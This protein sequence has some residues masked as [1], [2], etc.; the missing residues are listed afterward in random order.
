MTYAKTG[1]PVYSCEAHR[2]RY[3][4]ASERLACY[5]NVHLSH[6]FTNLESDISPAYRESLGSEHAPDESGW[7]TNT[8]RESDDGETILLSLDSGGD[9]GIYEANIFLDWLKS[10]RQPR[11]VPLILDDIHSEKHRTSVPMLEESF[12]V[13]VYQVEDRWGFTVINLL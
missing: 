9:V 1:L 2:K 8:L 12:G 13:D 7:L 3:L 6:A 11:T 10:Q 5:R 4:D